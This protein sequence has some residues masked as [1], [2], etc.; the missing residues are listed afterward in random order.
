M[1]RVGQ[2]PSHADGLFQ[3]AKI[4]SESGMM[5]AMPKNSLANRR[6]DF[7][8][9][10]KLLLARR[11]NHRCSN[12][13]CRRGTSGPHQSAEK[14]INVGFAA[15]ITAAAPGGPRY[16][17]ALSNRDRCSAKNGIWLCGLCAKLIDSDALRFTVPFLHAWKHDAEAVARWEIEG[18]DKSHE[19]QREHLPIP[20]IYG[21]SYHDARKLLIEAGWQPLATWWPHHLP[22]LNIQVGN[23]REFWGYGY[24][25]IKSTCPTGFA[26]CRFEFRDAHRSRLAVVTAG[27]ERAETK[28]QACVVSWFLDPAG[29]DLGAYLFAH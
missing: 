20:P 14:S 27:E 15:H 29:S 10:V 8:E 5:T 19:A 23:G 21:I 18:G 16:D 13:N 24:N 7:P 26:F 6:D 3:S 11:V 1:A 22:D 2:L 17:E 9:R 4:A 28:C 12:P 25:E